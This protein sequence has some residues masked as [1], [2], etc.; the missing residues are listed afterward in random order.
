MSDHISLGQRRDGHRPPAKRIVI[1]VEGRSEK[2][3][4]ERFR[5]PRGSIAIRMHESKNRTAEGVVE[6]CIS[7]MDGS[8]MDAEADEF[9]AVFDTDQNTAKTIEK[10]V[11]TASE[12]GIKVYISN[13]SFE[14]W[15]LLHFED[16]HTTHIQKDIEEALE[17]HLGFKLNL[18]T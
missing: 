7:L 2:T 18:R 8:G 10:A 16:D 1:V 9:I 15:L 17:R 12:N 4:F 3:Y 13:P 14:F 5:T 6:K 11:K